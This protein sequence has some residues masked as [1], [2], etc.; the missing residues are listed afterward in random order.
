MISGTIE[1]TEVTIAAESPGRVV[2][3]H[4]T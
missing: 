1:A 4:A 3:V 2:A